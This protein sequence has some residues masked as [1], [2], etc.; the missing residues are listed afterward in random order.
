MLV[1][2]SIMLALF[3][4]SVPIAFALG[5]AAL[6]FFI[7]RGLPL[8][9]IPQVIFDSMDSFVLLAVPLYVLAGRIM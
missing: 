1:L 3:A 6:P 8:I 4:L 9:A 5:I 7:G 2:V